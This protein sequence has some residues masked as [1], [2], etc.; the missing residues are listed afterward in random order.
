MQGEISNLAL[1][2]VGVMHF[3]SWFPGS[4]GQERFCIFKV[5]IVVMFFTCGLR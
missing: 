5:Q 1:A 2:H 3:L 4:K